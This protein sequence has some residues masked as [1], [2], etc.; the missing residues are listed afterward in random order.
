MAKIS[1]KN[2]KEV[3]IISDTYFNEKQIREILGSE[4]QSLFNKIFT[5]SDFRNGK[6]GQLHSIAHQWLDINSVNVLHFGDNYISDIE[7]CQITGASAILLPNGTNELLEIRERENKLIKS[8]LKSNTE[9][10]K[11]TFF[12]RQIK[13]SH[14]FNMDVSWGHF[15]YGG[16]ILGPILGEFVKWVYDEISQQKFDYVFLQ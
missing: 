13:V 1:L 7:K 10:I 11:S 16:Y 6:G 3:A 2:N 5:S 14:Y 15:A 8:R 4:Y 12:A 9:N